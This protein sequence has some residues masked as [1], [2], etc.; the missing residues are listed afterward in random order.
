MKSVI[1]MIIMNTHFVEVA[2]IRTIS[3]M[4]GKKKKC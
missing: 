3:Q 1:S 2:S 4:R